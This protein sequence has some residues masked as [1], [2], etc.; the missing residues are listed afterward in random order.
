MQ[1]ANKETTTTTT[2][3][4]SNNNNNNNKKKPVTYAFMYCS[5]QSTQRQYPRR[6]KLFFD[7]IGLEGDDDIEEQGQTFL[8]KARQDADWANQQI[9]MYLDYQ[10]QR[11]SH[12]EI[13]AGTLKQMWRPIKTFTDAYD[14]VADIIKWKRIS[15]AMP[16]AK[17]YSNDRI[18]TIEEIR[19]LV[20]FPD[21]R[22]KALVYT[23]V[24]SGIR[25]GAWEYLKW[26][27]ITPVQ[28]DKTGEVIAAKLIVYAGE[29]EEYFTF[30]T[31]EAFKALQDWMDFRT[32][33][34][35]QITGESWVL[36]NLFKIADVKREQ[37]G[38]LRNPR[39][40]NTGTVAN[41]KMMVTKSTNRLLIRA[42]YEQGLRESLEEG[43]HRHEF[44]TAHGFRK[45][46]KTRAEQVMNR[47]NV[48]FLLG[49]SIGLNSN[50]YKPTQQELLT[51]YLKAVPAL[52][53]NDNNVQSLKEEQ[54]KLEQKYQEKDVEL[55]QLK[56]NLETYEINLHKRIDVLTQDVSE[57]DL[58]IQRLRDAIDENKRSTA[59]M[60]K[61][62][63]ESKELQETVRRELLLQQQQRQEQE[64]KQSDSK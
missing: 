35:E 46:F 8:D 16:R 7:Y 30:I 56:A 45:Y 21:R 50:Y 32:L 59:E 44:K 52:T 9:M 19:K 23:M 11:V 13:T 18:P 3:A 12:K 36:R 43:K 47:L 25:I 26:K 55:K 2:I 6:L 41:P 49:H 14:D 27:H 4:A 28:N 17:E 15:R 61:S 31:P 34:G 38:N 20:E 53:I 40:G 22:I 51:D 10:R 54:E 29:P 5:S 58:W 57:R 63:K 24:S 1:V 33:Y 39:G 37:G 42:L 64:R 60:A 62:I 48:E